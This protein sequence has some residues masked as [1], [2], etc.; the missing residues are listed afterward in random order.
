MKPKAKGIL[1]FPLILLLLFPLHVYAGGKHSDLESQDQETST[2]TKDRPTL[3]RSNSVLYVWRDENGVT[4][5][6]NVPTWSLGDTPVEVESVRLSTLRA[7]QK[8]L[9][10]T[11]PRPSS[12]RPI[13]LVTRG[14]FAVQLVRELGLGENS[15]P[16]EAAGMLS[17]VR[18]AP[19]LGN[20][21]LNEVMTP[22]LT[23]RLRTLTVSAAQRGWLTV[24]PEQA[25]LAFDT[26][27]ALLG[28]NIPIL[29]NRKVPSS[30]KA[31][32]PFRTRSSTSGG[33]KTGSPHSVTFRPGPWA[34]PRL[35]LS[36]YVCQR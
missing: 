12:K 29:L 36:Q 4:T 8:G 30:H 7:S 35:R 14:D 18:I 28:I 27:A 1:G 17:G 26:A 34:I 31:D 20:W 11:T 23:T 5:F 22:E 24:T 33:M 32:R 2:L 6:S 25:L 19:R 21:E 10:E 16:Q 3:N 13:R 9:T 15:T